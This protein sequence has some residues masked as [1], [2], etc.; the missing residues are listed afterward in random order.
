MAAGDL[1]PKGG[2]AQQS[3]VEIWRPVPSEPGVMA[4]SWGRV[5]LPPRYAPMAKGGYR[6]YLPETRYGQISRAQKTASHEFM[7]VMVKAG[8]GVR[9]Q[10]P[11]K[12]HQ[13]VCEAFHG[14][15]PFPDAVV[16]H[17]DEDGKN[18]R[19]DNLKWG[20]Q[21]ENLNMPK[22]KAWQKSPERCASLK[23]KAG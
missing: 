8:D 18:N 16:I 23:R 11:R 4:S 13:L 6:S 21:K 15:R 3:N 22:F 10:R 19:P 9:T 2:I 17:I 12:V 1:Y 7:I 14:P 5:L 20:T